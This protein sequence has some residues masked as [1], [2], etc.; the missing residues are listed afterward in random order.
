[1]LSL[2]GKY[3]FIVEKDAKIKQIKEALERIYSVHIVKTNIVNVPAEDGAY[4][5]AIVTLKSGEKIDILPQ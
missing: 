1:M 3:V 2:A 4:K 5:K